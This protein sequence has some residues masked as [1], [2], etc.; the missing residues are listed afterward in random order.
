MTP[1]SWWNSARHQDLR[2]QPPAMMLPTLR[3][4]FS[5]K[6]PSAICLAAATRSGSRGAPPILTTKSRRS[7]RSAKYAIERIA[8]CMGITIDEAREQLE[9]DDFVA[10]EIAERAVQA[11]QAQPY[12]EITLP[13]SVH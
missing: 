4:A 10:I 3:M 2:C 12:I 1:E 9:F 13:Y 11:M 6:S 8:A 5:V 7:T